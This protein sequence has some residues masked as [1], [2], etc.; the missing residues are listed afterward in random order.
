MPGM[1]K[2]TICRVA[3]SLML[4]CFVANAGVAKAQ[5]AQA[6]LSGSLGGDE[7]ALGAAVKSLCNARVAM[8]GESATHGD[9]RTV[10]F[11]GALIERLVDQCGFDSVL[12][13]S[14]HYEFLHLNRMLRRG[15][16]VTAG[17]LLSAVG[18]IWE[19]DQE[20]QPLASF[21]V[22]RAESGRVFL[23]GLDDQLGQYGQDY[24]NVQMIAE[25]TDLLPGPD[26]QSCNAALHQRIY[27]DFTEGVPYS[28]P[29]QSRLL[30]CLAE[31]ELALG[32]DKA[33]DGEELEERKEMVSA[34]RRWVSRDFSPGDE[35][36]VERDRSM[37]EDLEWLQRH[38]PKRHKVILWAATVH[39]A[40]QASPEWGD[41]TGTNFGSLIH[42]KFG[43]DAFSL[44]FSA[45][46]GSYRMGGKAI[47]EMPAAPG[48]SV[49]TQAMKGGGAAASYV[50]RERLEGMGT[51]PGAFFYHSYQTLAWSTFLDGVVVFASEHP[52]V[53]TRR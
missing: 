19:F 38:L 13:E 36:I 9:G 29:D 15:Q 16:V 42:R 37:F 46:G 27:S 26:R 18:G 25:V 8:L 53:D 48:D 44:G 11:K 40:K 39:I 3:L 10:G 45:V 14:S 1:L 24:A 12:F 31:I 43:K 23:G 35:A 49:E 30:A 52:P 32:K 50:G 41:R 34:A 47:R 2:V 28:R 7:E 5:A 33:A 6:Q 51:L 22:A 4:V 20:F 21:L 17:D